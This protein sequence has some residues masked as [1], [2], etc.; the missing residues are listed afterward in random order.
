GGPGAQD[1]VAALQAQVREAI[2]ADTKIANLTKEIQI[3]RGRQVYMQTCFVC[4]Q[5]NGEGIA[6]QI[7]PLVKSDFLMADVERSIQ[8][9]L[10]GR[11]G[12]IEVNGK[13]FN[14]TMIPLNNLAD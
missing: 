14:G 6:G 13:K 5:P 1:R 12:E 7:P 8:I 4:H 9:V 3:E 2:S 11:T 10:Q